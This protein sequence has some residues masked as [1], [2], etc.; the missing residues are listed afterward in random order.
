MTEKNIDL[1]YKKMSDRYAVNLDQIDLNIVKTKRKIE[2]LT[3]SLKNPE[4][5]TKSDTIQT[6]E[7]ELFSSNENDSNNYLDFTNKNE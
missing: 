1:L 6:L 5:K 2:D 4:N 7:A 3:V